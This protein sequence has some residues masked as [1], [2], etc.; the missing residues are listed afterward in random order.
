MNATLRSAAP[1][2][3][4]TMVAVAGCAYVATHDPY[5]SA[6]AFPVCP[7]QFITGLSC[8][9]CGGLR[10]M[11][12]LLHSDVRG[13]AAANAFLLVLV[14]VAITLWLLWWRAALRGKDSPPLT[15]AVSKGLL[16]IAVVWTVLRNTV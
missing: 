9:A 13:A 8:P 6:S 3:A 11:R 7:T 10:M 4:T 1:P 5:D 15:P 2:L 12:S 14:P 16:G